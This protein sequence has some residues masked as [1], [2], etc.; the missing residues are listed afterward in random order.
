MAP[1]LAIADCVS[2]LSHAISESASA[3]DTC[4][5][6]SM[7]LSSASSGAMPPASVIWACT[8]LLSCASLASAL[9]AGF[10]AFPTPSRL[11][12]S[13]IEPALQMLRCTSQLKAAAFAIACAAKAC[14]APELPLRIAM[15]CGMAPALMM[16][17]WWEMS[18]SSAAS[19]DAATSCTLG[20]PILSRV[21]S[22]TIPP[23]ATTADC[24]STFPSERTP[25]VAAADS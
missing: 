24:A 10:C 19:A 2:A 16:P 9:A 14:A 15:R 3:A 7:P 8:S 4:A 1:A 5:S 22:G 21:T 25:S 17:C 23:A 11:S 18:A 13:G 6:M 20:L 12:S